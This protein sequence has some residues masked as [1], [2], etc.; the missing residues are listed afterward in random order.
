MGHVFEG[1]RPALLDNLSQSLMAPLFLIAEVLF[2]LGIR[3]D[4]ERTV[5]ERVLTYKFPGEAAS[6]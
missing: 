5:H 2:F 1:R 6:G 4:L 3:K